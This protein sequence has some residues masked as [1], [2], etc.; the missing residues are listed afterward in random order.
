LER[1]PATFQDS[2]AR[3][4]KN[5][6][7]ETIEEDSSSKNQKIA[8]VDSDSRDRDSEIN[9]RVNNLVLNAGGDSNAEVV[10]ARIDLDGEVQPTLKN[11]IDKDV[12]GLK[13]S[14]ISLNTE[15]N[16]V[17]QK[18]A[19]LFSTSS[20]INTGVCVHSLYDGYSVDLDD[21]SAHGFKIIRDV[22]AWDTV[23]KVKGIYDFSNWDTLIEGIVSRGM[24][25]YLVLAYGNSLYTDDQ[26]ITTEDERA[27]FVAYAA[28]ATNHFS[29]KGAI[30]EIWNEPDNMSFWTPANGTEI[31]DIDITN[32]CNLVKQIYNVIKDNDPSGV[33]A[34]PAA[35][36]DQFVSPEWY[37]EPLFKKGMLDYV[38]ILSFHPYRAS[39]PETAYDNYAKLAGIVSKY[40]N[41]NVPV[42]FG[43]WGYS[44]TANWNGQG[45]SS[46][47]SKQ[48][49]ADYYVR[50]ILQNLMF[51]ISFTNFYEWMDEGTSDSD[52]ECNFGMV[53]R[54]GIDK[55]SGKALEFVNALL[56]GYSYAGRVKLAR[57]DDYALKFVNASGSIYAF[58]TTI[59]A[60]NTF[61]QSAIYGKI[62]S[63]DGSLVADFNS[64]QANITNSVQF[65]KTDGLIVD[66]MVD[67]CQQNLSSAG[68]ALV[69]S[70]ISDI[71]ESKWTPVTL[72]NG[73]TGFLQVK[74][75]V[76]NI[77]AIRG[78]IANLPQGSIGTLPNWAFPG[79]N[80]AFC[81]PASGD[82]FGDLTKNANFSIKIDG[83]VVCYPTES[84]VVSDNFTLNIVY[85][86]GDETN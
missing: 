79:F 27:A 80:T 15:L 70:K 61:F 30:W 66:V 63:Q 72:Q 73:A 35:T 4:Q 23:E 12:T 81:A 57:S 42:V 56:S 11:R 84:T 67:M 39:N 65:I 26:S 25:P 10:D 77:C 28:A 24:T 53:D 46:V 86:L 1:E 83:N 2:K 59:A 69:N 13:D 31:S 54:S 60:H 40:T 19:Y 3:N 21:I 37:S 74:K 14:V 82:H 49:Q 43:E 58:W 45:I 85:F 38:D 29:G 33:V 8:Q 50:M 20:G 34:A 48:T 55:P 75:L 5:Y 41:K 64:K 18:I 44:T 22:L 16:S 78:Y 51:G 52:V 47:V 6:N 9:T 32:Y 7:W 62:Y 76:N 36:N 17:E 71:T 68:A